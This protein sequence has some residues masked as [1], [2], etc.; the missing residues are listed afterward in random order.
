MRGEYR[1]EVPVWGPEHRDRE[2]FA[3]RSAAVLHA[4]HLARTARVLV[5]VWGFGAAMYVD[6]FDGRE[7]A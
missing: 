3:T 1:I 2:V 7:G 6:R 4:M 5:L